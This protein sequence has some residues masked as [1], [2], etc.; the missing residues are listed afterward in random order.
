MVE[1]V[2]SVQLVEL[3]LQVELCS[4][5][6]FVRNNRVFHSSGSYTNT[7]DAATGVIP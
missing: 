2:H 4:G 6:S 7:V 3:N 1:V 5:D